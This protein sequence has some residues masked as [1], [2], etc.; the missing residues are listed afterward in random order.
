MF[1][2]SLILFLLVILSSS[3]YAQFRWGGGRDDDKFHYGYLI[4]YVSTRLL[5]YR[6]TNWQNKYY[7][8]NTKSYITDE[9]RSIKSTSQSGVSF[10]LITNLVLY[11]N[12]DLRVSP[13]LLFSDRELEYTY[14]D[15]TTIQKM[16][17][18]PSVDIPVNLKIRSDRHQNMR[19]YVLTGVCTSVA[20]GS[21]ALSLTPN[22]PPLKLLLRNSRYYF[23]Y[24]AGV[25][26]DLYLDF[27]RASLEVKFVN[28]FNN[29]L[30]QDNTAFSTP[31]EKLFLQNFQI[32][33]VFE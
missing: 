8:V 17:D 28:S 18:Y 14:A 26:V 4:R 22:S 20:I 24:E 16:S 9:L 23:G 12:L 11:D 29:I 31:L 19:F 3:S 5:V 25:G 2:K 30:I 1:K 32:G 10:G 21:N 15:G 13:C 7:D 33:V 27:F 6:N